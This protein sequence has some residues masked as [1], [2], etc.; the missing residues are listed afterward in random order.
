MYK[1]AY[2][3]RRVGKVKITK[4]QLLSTDFQ[5]PSHIRIIECMYDYI[6]QNYI[7]TFVS[8]NIDKLEHF[9]KTWRIVPEFND[10]NIRELLFKNYRIVYEIKWKTIRIITIFHWA[11]LL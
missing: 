4:E 6:F 1:K 9:P 10:E 3:E 2:K 5:F 7:Y 11:K 8:P